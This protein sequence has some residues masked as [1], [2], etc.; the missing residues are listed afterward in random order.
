MTA[1]HSISVR[2]YW[3]DTDA[4][5]LIYH[6]AY[7]CFMERGRTELLRA[8][9]LLQSDLLD[10]AAGHP[11]YFVVRK[12][13]VDFRKPGALDDLL[14]VETAVTAIGG[15]SIDLDQ[16]VARDGETLVSARVRVVCV[17][18]GRACRLPAELRAR[19]AAAPGPPKS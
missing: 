15:A 18:E 6:A 17:A 11:L 5:G 14:T 10:G 7:I 19:F 4:S 12:M 2:V 1:R 13:E 9:G 16:R 3:E 8:L